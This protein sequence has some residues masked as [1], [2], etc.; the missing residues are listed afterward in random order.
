MVI[1]D[2]IHIEENI[3]PVET[4]CSF[5]KWLNKEDDKFQKAAIVSNTGGGQVVDE[6]ARKVKKNRSALVKFF[7]FNNNKFEK[8]L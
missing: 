8:K 6:R 3:M 4:L 5:I 2:L 1:K 7:R